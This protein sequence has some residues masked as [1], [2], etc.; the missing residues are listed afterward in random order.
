MA[1]PV[2]EKIIA[3]CA[4]VAE[5]D[6]LNDCNRFVKAV[7]K[8]F[9]S[10]NPFSGNINADGMI[11]RMAQGGV[12]T[13]IDTDSNSHETAIARA[14]AGE[15]VIAGM[16]GGDLSA[17]NGHVAVVIGRDG[18]HSPAAEK[19][20]PIGY[21]GS[22]DRPSARIKGKRL[23]DTFPAVHFKNNKVQY[24]YATP[25]IQPLL[26]GVEY[27]AAF[28]AKGSTKR[29]AKK[30]LRSKSA[31]RRATARSSRPARKK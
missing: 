1:N 16:K 12:W 8:D 19:K 29:A 21:A 6:A 31:K 9:M 17:N 30:S 14:K 11:D 7:T 23:S 25:N 4:T 18:Q 28:I 10:P 20:V 22:I 13:S 5:T 2:A 15:L 24:F 27:L 26:S 3:V